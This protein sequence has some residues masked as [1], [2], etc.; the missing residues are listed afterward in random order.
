MSSFFTTSFF[1]ISSTPPVP[2]VSEYEKDPGLKA[3]VEKA[4]DPSGNCAP[5]ITEDTGELTEAQEKSLKDTMGLMGISTCKATQAGFRAEYK[6]SV[7]MARVGGAVGANIQTQAGCEEI[8]V[9]SNIANQC[10]KQLSCMLNDVQSNSS[11]NVRVFQ[12]IYL[13]VGNIDS[14]K[15]TLGNQS[16]T[17]VSLV[18]I[19]QSTVQSAI[20]ATLTQGLNSAIDQSLDLKAGPHSDA[21]SQKNVT[22]LLK[23]LKSVASNTTVNKSVAKASADMWKDQKIKLYAGNITGSTLDIRNVDK[24]KM[25]S[26]NY[27]YNALD[28]LFKTDQVQQSLDQI[29]QKSTAA[30]GG[31]LAGVNL[32][33]FSAGEIV[34][35][36]FLIL[37]IVL[38]LVMIALGVK[39]YLGKKAKKNNNRQQMRL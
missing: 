10:T 18:N 8:N 32:G 11:A 34:G 35:Y 26:E 4:T 31:A 2:G 38:I 30:K 37:G 29:V 13:D 22:Q 16:D 21:S 7:P 5:K 33:G 1:P 12:E 24:I 25:I 23:N 28:Q 19:A 20:G 36:V 9:I 14:S 15:I 17:D 6:A 27:V 3:A 39:W